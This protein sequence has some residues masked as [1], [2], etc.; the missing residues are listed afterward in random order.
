MIMITIFIVLT[1]QAEAG[2]NVITTKQKCGWNN[3]TRNVRL[4]AVQN[5]TKPQVPAQHNRIKKVSI[6]MS[7]FRACV[8]LRR[9]L[10]LKLRSDLPLTSRTEI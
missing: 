8:C 5:K 1:R 4:T 2:T 3:Q 10:S 9:S 6:S 7:M